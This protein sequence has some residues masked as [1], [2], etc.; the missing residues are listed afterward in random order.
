[1]TGARVEVAVSRD[2]LHLTA[3]F[4]VIKCLGFRTQK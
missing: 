3:R 4:V 1:M 2:G